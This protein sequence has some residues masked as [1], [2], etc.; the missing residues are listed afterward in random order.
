[1]SKIV[2]Y[3]YGHKIEHD[4]RTGEDRYADTGKLVSNV[5]RPCPRCGK[6]AG[7]DDIDP[8][9][10]KLPGVKFAC[11]GHGIEDGYIAFENGISIYFKLV[12]VHVDTHK[13]NVL[14][15]KSMITGKES[16]IKYK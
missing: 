11:C 7:K 3:Y 5:K 10:G 9:F 15:S 16:N 13:N 12:D 6:I 14:C 2:G 1:M 8:C 4:T